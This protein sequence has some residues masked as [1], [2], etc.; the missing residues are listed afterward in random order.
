MIR[1][2]RRVGDE[3]MRYLGSRMRTEQEMRSHLM[4]KE[5][6]ED[7]IEGVIVDLKHHR[8]IDDYEY[9]MAFYRISF[10]K[11]RG[12]MRA[13]REL[14]QRGVESTLAQ[15]ALEDYMYQE[16]IDEYSNALRIAK[17]E[18][19][20]EYNFDVNSYEDGLTDESIMEKISEKKVA[21]IARKL[22]NLGYNSGI[23]YK[24]IGVIS[25][26]KVKV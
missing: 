24:V 15:N 1:K 9:A 20:G 5:Y 11:L 7:E 18:I 19:F 3:A 25:N 26:W 10:E 6:R 17:K 4:L 12:S 22:E 14:I 13:K 23:I 21:A 2:K 8:Y 16:S